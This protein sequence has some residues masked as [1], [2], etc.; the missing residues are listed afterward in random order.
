MAEH[1]DVAEHIQPAWPVVQRGKFAGH[2]IGRENIETFKSPTRSGGL[3]IVL[4]LLEA[5]STGER[6]RQTV[7]EKHKVSKVNASLL[8]HLGWTKAS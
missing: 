1:L 4:A 8:R 6:S 7:M 5:I 3:A 2:I